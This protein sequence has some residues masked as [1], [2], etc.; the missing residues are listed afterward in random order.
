M[1]WSETL[2]KLTLEQEMEIARSPR[3]SSPAR[4]DAYR[5]HEV[6]KWY[7]VVVLPVPVRLDL[8][9]LHPQDAAEVVALRTLVGFFNPPWHH[10]QELAA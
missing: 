8:T 7:E 4:D 2:L 6:K 1:V 3:F 10:R 9:D 5:R